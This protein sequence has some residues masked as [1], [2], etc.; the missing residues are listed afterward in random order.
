MLPETNNFEFDDFLLNT[1]E[2][3]LLREG[4]PVSITPK[5]F[6]LLLALIE[7]YGHIVEKNELMKTIWAD[8]FV[9]DGNLTFTVNLLRKALRDESRNPR[10]IETVPRRGYRFIAEVK[11]FPA[12]S[13]ELPARNLNSP[14]SQQ[15]LS[16][17]RPSDSRVFSVAVFILITGLM[18]FGGWYLLNS[19]ATA[20]LPILDAPFASEKLSTTGTIGHAVISPDGKMMVYSNTGRGKQSV[21][22]RQLESSNNVEIIPPSD[23]VYVGFALSPDGNFLYFSRIPKGFEGQA[24]IYRVSIFGGIP[25]KVVRETQGWISISPDGEKISFVRCYY[26]DDEFCSLWIADSADGK[27]ERMLVSR[28][29]PLRIADN[30]ISPDGKTVAFAVGQSNNQ[31]NDFGLAEVNIENGEERKLTKE[32]FFNVKGLA[33][34]PDRSGLILTASRIPENNF[35]IWH[36]SAASGEIEPLTKDS[37]TY[38]ELSLDSAA[39]RLVSTQIKEDFH[40]RLFNMKNPSVK[41]VLI[42]AATAFF[43]PGGKIVFSSSMSGNDEIWSI[44]ADGGGQ[45]QLT[46]DKAGDSKPAVSPDGGSIFFASNRSGEVQVWGMKSDGSDQRQ[47][48][49]NQGGFPLS[50]SSDGKWVYYHHGLDRTLWRV[51]VESGEEQSVFD[52]A[53]YRFALSPDGSQIAFPE[54]RDEER[55]LVIFSLTDQ[56]IIQVFKPV[57]EKNR[58]LDVVWM[59]DGKSLLYISADKNF[60]NNTLWLQGLDEEKPRKITDLS[61]EEVSEAT[62]LA[63]APDG[64]TFSVVQGG[65][66]RDAVLIKGLR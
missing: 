57:L 49:K 2:K 13:A 51:S 40:L 22:L 34:L 65:W 50:I 31:A 45:R 19:R 4:K 24:D 58:I 25:A 60:E 56:K 53:K 38:S 63:L 44:N 36:L 42:K 16:E 11:K 20:K 8:S 6:Q 27:N 18:T 14:A 15:T 59:P 23:D 35:L 66:R 43:A 1:K 54:K 55:Y 41:R 52:K 9:E 62:G 29:R 28:P 26:R 3:V 5:T 21:W 47:I 46:N 39:S 7:N 32:K 61:D 33:W 37:E 64:Q 10:F 30:K 48:T 12:A 17:R